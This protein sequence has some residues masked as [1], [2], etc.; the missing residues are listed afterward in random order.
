M[1]RR[2]FVAS[3]GVPAAL[4]AIFKARG[5]AH[6]NGGEAEVNEE[7]SPNPVWPRP[8]I[9]PVPDTTAG[10]E[11]PVRSLNGAWKFTLRPPTRFWSNEVNPSSWDDIEVP[12]ECAMQGFEIA[13]DT[14]YPFKKSVPIPAD[15]QGKR[16][17]LRFDGL[18]SYGRVWVNGHYVRDHRGG[19]TSWD[20]DI[21]PFI[22]AGKE[23]WITVS[24]TDE[25]DNISWQSNYAKHYIGGILRDVRI[26]AIPADYI[27]RLHVETDF[28]SSF[29]NAV[30]SV[31]LG[32][33]LDRARDSSVELS[34]KNPG[35]K[36]IPIRPALVHLSR[37][38][39]ETV[40][41]IPVTRPEKWDCEHPRLYTLEVNVKGSGSTTQT[42]VKRFGFRKV[43]TRGNQVY[44]NGEPVKLHGGCRHDVYPT[45]GRSTT[46]ALDEQDVLL[47]KS[48][49]FDFVR[50]SHYPPTENFLDYCDRHGLYIE[51]ETAVCFV[52]QSFGSHIAAQNDSHYTA[53]FMN[54]FA[55]MIERDRDHPCIIIWSLGNESKWGS[56]FAKEYSYVKIEDPT[57]PVI[58]SFPDTVPK[59]AKAYD[60]FS[61]HYP[62][63]N[64]DFSSASIP[65]LND[66]FGHVPCYNHWTLRRDPG[67]RN[68]WGK[69]IK[70]FWNGMSAASGCLG[71][72]IWASIDEV[73]MLPGSCLGYGE[74]GIID[75]WRRQKPEYWLAKN[76]YSPTRLSV[77]YV[78]NPGPGNP[79][80]IPIRNEFNHTNLNEVRIQ[81]S[82]GPDQSEIK[83]LGVAPHSTGL[84]VVPGRAW[85]NGEIVNVKFIDRKNHLLDEY[86][87][88]VGRVVW[89][90]PP[91]Q[92]PAPRMLE[93]TET[94]SVAGE[95]FE[96]VFSKASGLIRNAS[97]KRHRVVVG[98]P[99]LNLVPF[100]L[101]DWWLTS[102]KTR[103][104]R[105]E[106]VIDISGNYQIAGN[107]SHQVLVYAQFQ[108]R[109]DAGGLVTTDFKVQRVPHGVDEIGVAYRLPRE[110]DQLSWNR[111]ALWSVYP[112][113]HIGR[114]TGVAKKVRS[115]GQGEY[116][117]KPTWPWSEDMRDFF[118]FGKDDSDGRG[119]NDFRSQKQNIWFAS[120]IVSPTGA[121]VRAES[122]ATHAV[123]TEIEG[124]GR[125]RMN[126]N[127]A[128]AYPDMDWG[129]ECPAL[130]TPP[131]YEGSVRLRLTDN[132]SIHLSFNDR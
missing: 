107:L 42:L 47:L 109:V 111:K 55:E 2:R 74:W 129:N 56:N 103:M 108:V 37:E 22:T 3:L 86:E 30:L 127:S 44:V 92:G 39:P 25:S 78:E 102:L 23:A 63:F 96:I 34:L 49:N 20:C 5:T 54:Q 10:V 131:V 77:R 112:S 67:V 124:D 12:G 68:Y 48:A 41:S 46:P 64:S 82:V 99:V 29:T 59:G 73:F 90:F 6:Q 66:E 89:N 115:A 119:T 123:R 14:E 69:S 85:R 58:F 125:V 101:R 11:T 61:K 106:V 21:T 35:G 60:I 1:N 95:H 75:G 18:Y 104:T 17:F 120:G 93:D 32:M 83:D 57:R 128:W 91:V 52:D 16:I 13:R 24:V 80:K 81:W 116:R 71:G 79:L 33:A 38:A 87:L 26:F 8:V 118:L 70:E 72:S 53:Q 94:I 76:A 51:E 36:D 15:F 45:R 122:E 88:P 50:T 31:A 62:K 9:V 110:T 19:F 28:D 27:T 97:F 130:S 65:R 114:I 117:A 132:D 43:E 40:L 113:D 105:D 4:G 84:L 121:R 126:I 100:T 7:S 98:G